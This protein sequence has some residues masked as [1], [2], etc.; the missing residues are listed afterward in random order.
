MSFDLHFK[1][2]HLESLTCI[3]TS[4]YVFNFN[5]EKIDIV[6]TE[7]AD[8]IFEDK[9]KDGN[10]KVKNM[11]YIKARLYDKAVLD[12]SHFRKINTLNA[13]LKDFSKILMPILPA[14]NLTFRAGDST[15]IAAPSSLFKLGFEK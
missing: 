13:E 5:Q 12:L 15:R 6:L 2:P 14:D 3:N 10:D 9:D 7:Q 8:V 11:A 4:P 1:M